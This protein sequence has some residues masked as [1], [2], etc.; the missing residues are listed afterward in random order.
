VTEQLSI[1]CGPADNRG[2]RIVTA[3]LGG[4]THRSKLDCD[5]AFQRKKFREEVSAKFGLG[6]TAHEFIESEVLRVADAED[7]SPAQLWQ[8]NIV[9]LS[10]VTASEPDFLWPG[11]IAFKTLTCIDGD[12]GIGKGLSLMSIAARGSAGAA[13]PPAMSPDGMFD[14]WSTLFITSEDVPEFILLPRAEAAGAD[15]DRID[16][17]STVEIPDTEKRA[18]ALLQD[19]ALLERVVTEGNY[20]MLVIDPWGEFID[21]KFNTNSDADN[22]KVLGPLAEMAQRTDCAVVLVR[23]LNKK[24][25]QSAQ[26]RGGGSTAPLNASRAAFIVAPDPD[27]PDVRVLACTKFNI[28]KKPLSLRFRIEQAGTTARVVWEG[29]CEITAAELVKTQH[30]SGGGKIEQAKDIIREI[31]SAGSRG[32]NEVQGACTAAGISTATYRRARSCLGIQSEK[33]DFRGEWLLSLPS[34]NGVDHADF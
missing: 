6:E 25:G 21:A 32:E 7:S 8:P 12:G 24:E 31:L 28:G 4:K 26:Y 11:R 2:V 33:T 23:H 18:V 27:D 19:I 5:N 16:T 10:Q 29:E 13:M 17:L 22:R 20:R 9:K 15:V 14:P 3:T 30:Q 34:T 1:A